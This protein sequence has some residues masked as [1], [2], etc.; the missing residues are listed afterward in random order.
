MDDGSTAADATKQPLVSTIVL[1]PFPA[2]APHHAQ[3]CPNTSPNKQKYHDDTAD[4][5]SEQHETKRQKAE[6]GAAAIQYSHNQHDSSSD[7]RGKSE[8]GEEKERDKGAR[9][10]SD[11]DVLFVPF[12]SGSGRPMLRIRGTHIEVDGEHIDDGDVGPEISHISMAVDDDDDDE[13]DEEDAD[14]DERQEGEEDEK[15][16]GTEAGQKGEDEDEDGKEGG[17]DGEAQMNDEDDDDENDEDYEPAEHE[18]AELQED[19][20]NLRELVERGVLVVDDDGQEYLLVS[21][22]AAQADEDD[23]DEDDEDD[24]DEHEGEEEEEDDAEGGA[25]GGAGGEGQRV[26]SSE[27]DVAAAEP[28]RR[29]RSFRRRLPFSSSAADHVGDVDQEH[30]QPFLRQTHHHS[31]YADKYPINTFSHTRQSSFSVASVSSASASH[32]AALLHSSFLPT[33]PFTHSLVFPAHVFCGR[34]SPTGETYCCASQ[35][36]FIHLFTADPLRRF[37]SIECRDVEW[38]IIDVDFSHNQR[39]VVYSGWS[40]SL[41]LVNVPPVRANGEAEDTY[42]LHEALDLKPGFGRSCMFSVRFNPTDT[43]LLAGLNRGVLIVYDIERRVNVLK[44]SAHQDDI[45]TV[46][47]LDAGDGWGG[48][49]GAGNVMVTGSDDHLI[50]VWDRRTQSCIGGWIA[51]TDG[52]TSVVSCCDGQYVLSNSKDQTMKLH[53]LR[54]MIKC[55]ELAHFTPTHQPLDYR[56]R[57]HRHHIR[58]RLPTDHSLVTYSGHTVMQTLIRC[59]VSPSTVGRQYVYSG[60]S[61]GHIY[62]WHAVTA[63]VAEVLEGHDAIVRE[64]HWSPRGDCLMSASWDETIKRWQYRENVAEDLL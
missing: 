41:Q 9:T 39:F 30:V 13:D 40:N 54:R 50:K 3:H 12:V 55:S 59:G 23:D 32:S 16:G 43:E 24:E 22:D 26:Y 20:H 33:A 5:D 35:D 6:S 57:R 63:E 7:R 34:F 49:G 17:A 36:G 47:Y 14:G 11:M 10:A 52:L 19:V 61:D 53:D 45:N 56:Y 46:C 58:S 51:H 44:A 15:D 2:F 48:G 25:E 42:E 28:G 31:L 1:D 27:E 60:S 29:L 4:V 38:A 21:R 37:K 62:V 64:V 8:L 18:E